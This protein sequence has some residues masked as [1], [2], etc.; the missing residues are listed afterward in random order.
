LALSL[1]LSA[2]VGGVLASISAQA[3]SPQLS[4]FAAGLWL[5]L[6][7]VGS[8]TASLFPAVRASRLTVRQT[9]AHT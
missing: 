1:I 2:A 5:A 9:L 3:L 8:L 7:L 4:P 6:V